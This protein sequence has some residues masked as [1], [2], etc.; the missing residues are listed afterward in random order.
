M[1]Q[2]PCH[3]KQIV[4]LRRIEGQVRGLQ[5]MID[6]K[7]YCV[8]ILTQITS[9]NAALLRVQDKI[10]E[11]H[12]K[13]CLTSALKGKSEIDREKKVSEIFDLLKRFRK[14]G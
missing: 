1:K 11:S 14:N 2:H 10:L 6:E 5:K 8:D 3:T 12:L 13:G 4:A 7:R 9:V